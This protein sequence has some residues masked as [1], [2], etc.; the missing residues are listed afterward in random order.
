VAERRRAERE[1]AH[2]FVLAADLL[3][4]LGFDGYFKRLNPAWEQLLF[5][6]SDELLTRPFLELLHP[7][8]LRLGRALLRQVAKGEEVRE[9][10]FRLCCRGGGTA[11]CRGTP[12]PWRRPG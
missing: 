10:D 2:F 12:R 8:D 9:L 11:G 7:H 5:S 4:I 1:L 3:C 6:A